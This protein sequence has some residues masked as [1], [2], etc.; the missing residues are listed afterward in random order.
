MEINKLACRYILGYLFF[1]CVNVLPGQES[2]FRNKDS[3]EE[4]LSMQKM[5]NIK[6]GLCMTGIRNDTLF[7][8]FYIHYLN[9][10]ECIALADLRN[11][12]TV[13]TYS[14]EGDYFLFYDNYGYIFSQ[15]IDSFMDL[16]GEENFV[17]KQ[18][19]NWRG[20]KPKS[21]GNDECFKSRLMYYNRTKGLYEIEYETIQSIKEDCKDLHWLYKEGDFYYP[22]R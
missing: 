2:P 13:I 5:E 18:T 8:I 17:L 1:I 14:S 19:L 15:C 3:F 11:K 21:L 7:V 20:H 16:N 9:R 22:P 12:A 10:V 6:S 4:Q